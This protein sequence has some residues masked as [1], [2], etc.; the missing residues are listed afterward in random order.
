MNPFFLLYSCAVP[1]PKYQL[2][3]QFPRFH[4]QIAMEFAFDFNAPVTFP[5]PS[6]QNKKQ[7]CLSFVCSIQLDFLF[8]SFVVFVES[9]DCF[10]FSD[11]DKALALSP[12][13][14]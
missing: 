13:L 7:N 10:I 11:K 5:L 1:T 8:C 4:R 9:K 3:T 2:G 6:Q 14:K 12:V